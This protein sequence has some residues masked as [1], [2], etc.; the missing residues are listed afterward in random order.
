MVLFADDP[1]T[2]ERGWS[3]SNADV[4]ESDAGVRDRMTVSGKVTGDSDDP[5]EIRKDTYSSSP[6]LRNRST[7][8]RPQR[9]SAPMT[10]AR[11]PLPLPPSFFLHGVDDTGVPI[12]GTEEFIKLL[13]EKG[14]NEAKVLY[15]TPQ[16][17]HGFEGD[18]SLYDGDTGKLW[19][20]EGIEFVEREWLANH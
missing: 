2:T 15:K 1:T 19:L 3:A 14:Y 11:S 4:R 17:D 5:T 20:R 6:I 10:R 13:R 8:P 12:A 16:G 18:F 9:P 7:A